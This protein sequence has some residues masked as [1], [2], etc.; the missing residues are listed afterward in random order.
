[1]MSKEEKEKYEKRLAAMTKEQ[2]RIE[3]D[4]V[5]K[6]F[7]EISKNIKEQKAKN[8]EVRSKIPRMSG[9]VRFA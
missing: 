2:L 5:T 1:M 7:K 9:G 4:S 6:D 3:W 8:E